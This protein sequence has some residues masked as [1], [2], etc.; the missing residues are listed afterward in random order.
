M[1]GLSTPT[2]DI[3]G[4]FILPA[5][6]SNPYQG[7]RRGTVTA[8][9]DGGISVYDTGYSVGDQTLTATILY[10]T[11]S[12][13][14]RLRYLVAYY[15]QIQVACESGLFLAIPSFALNAHMLTLNFRLIRRLDT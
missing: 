7:Q 9:L 8:T 2:Y 5:R 6:A 14:D 11:I 1:I 15:G 13:L 12:L 3:S 10:P 4:A